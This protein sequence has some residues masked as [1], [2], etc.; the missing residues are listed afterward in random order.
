MGISKRINIIFR[1]KIPSKFKLNNFTKIIITCILTFTLWVIFRIQ[2]FNIMILFYQSLINN[3]ETFIYLENLILFSLVIL[4]IYS[5]K[6]D[7]YY[8]IEKLAQ[9]FN[10]TTIL[11]I[12]IIIILT[13]SNKCWIF[14]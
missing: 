1:K 2:D 5:Q 8:Y 7:N 9:K 6:F 10:L 12:I 13:V 14:R 3:L 11:P 4:A